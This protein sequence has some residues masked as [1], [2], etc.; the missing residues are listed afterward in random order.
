[1]AGMSFERASQPSN[2]YF[3]FESG[4]RGGVE[5]GMEARV[6][7]RTPIRR[8]TPVRKLTPADAGRKDGMSKRIGNIVIIEPE[9]ESRCDLCG[10]LAETRPYGPHGE[11]VCFPCCMKDEPAAKRQMGRILFGEGN[12]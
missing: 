1:M 10:E 3:A 2:P 12:A 11:R 6:I 8:S 5:S 9:Q 4:L 7:R